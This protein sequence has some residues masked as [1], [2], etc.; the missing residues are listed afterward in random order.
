MRRLWR[1]YGINNIIY[2]LKRKM[3]F[4]RSSPVDF[5]ALKQQGTPLDPQK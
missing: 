5:W 4:K 1:F 2:I 3:I